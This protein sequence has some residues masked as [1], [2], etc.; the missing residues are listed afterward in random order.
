MFLPTQMSFPAV[1]TQVAFEARPTLV[2]AMHTDWELTAEQRALS[3]VPSLDM[4]IKVCPI[5]P[6]FSL[7]PL[8]LSF[9]LSL[10]N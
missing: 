7:P 4:R 8:S 1:P 10:P 5:Y 2:P 3:K 6:P 9:S